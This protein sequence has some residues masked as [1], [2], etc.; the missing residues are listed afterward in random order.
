[1]SNKIQNTEESRLERISKDIQAYREA[2]DNAEGALAE[3]E[4][5]LVDELERYTDE[6]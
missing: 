2:I 5:E 3:A 1:M 4:R 6:V